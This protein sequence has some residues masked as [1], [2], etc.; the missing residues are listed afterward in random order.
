MKTNKIDEALLAAEQGRAQALIDLMKSRYDL[1]RSV[2]PESYESAQ[3]I[4]SILSSIPNQMVF[5][6][7]DGDTINFWVLCKGIN[8]KAHN[9]Q[10]RQKKI[11]RG[12][13]NDG[14][15]LD[16]LVKNALRKIRTDGKCEDRSLDEL[17]DETLPSDESRSRQDAMGSSQDNPLCIL[18]DHVISPIEDLLQCDELIIVPDGPLCLAPFAA[19]VGLD[20]KYVCESFRIRL[21]P[22]LTSLKV[23]TDCPDGFHS[24]SGALLVG[25]PWVQEIVNKRR[26]KPLLPQLPCAREEVEMIGKIL[27]TASLIGE[28][29]TKE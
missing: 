7:V 14:T 8:D 24:E 6:A 3:T 13:E 16:D 25:D 23:I 4:S 17:R 2:G 21:V 27:N 11:E 10:L 28:Q 26:K 19:F 12:T 9:V 18:Y 1:L 22:S 5:L 29:A 20:S 15:K